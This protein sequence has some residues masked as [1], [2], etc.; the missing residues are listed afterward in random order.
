MII[1]PSHLTGKKPHLIAMVHVPATNAL[2]NTVYNDHLSV[3]TYSPSDLKI[4]TKIRTELIKLHES[5][6]EEHQL[7]FLKEC[8]SSTFLLKR[9]ETEILENELLSIP[10]IRQ[11]IDRAISEVEIYNKNGIEI[12]EIENIGAPYFIGHDVPLEELA[13]LNLVAKTIRKKFPKLMIGVHVLAGDELE[14]LPIAILSDAYFVRS[15]TSIFSGFRPEGQMQNKGNLAKFFFLRNYFQ[16]FLGVENP[17]DRRYPQIWSDL[18]KKHTVFEQELQD[19]NLWLNNILFMKLEGIILTG[20]ATGK[21]IS[22]KDMILARQAIDNLKQL[23]KDYF[24]EEVAIPLISGSGLDVELYKKNADYII[25]GTQLKKNKY[26]ENP[27]EEE[28][29]KELIHKFQE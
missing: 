28:K 19:L 13:I 27:V 2:T 9:D 29:V 7:S 1:N 3:T 11:L 23:T 4:L 18:Q 26:W 20:E 14:S 17:K 8:K 5:I 22:E 25:T 6:V 24:S 15:E 21:N 16:A 10:F 12:I